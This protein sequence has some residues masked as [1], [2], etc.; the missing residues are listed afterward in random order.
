[1][2]IE[3]VTSSLSPLGSSSPQT[4]QS[5]EV[6]HSPPVQQIGDDQPTFHRQVKSLP[7][8]LREHC[9]IYFE[10]GLCRLS[11]ASADDPCA[12]REYRL[13][14]LEPP[15]SPPDF[16]SSLFSTDTGHPTA[17]TAPGSDSYASSS[18]YLNYAC[19][20]FR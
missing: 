11:K 13:P 6:N 5:A 16:C 2:D 12:D 7:Y 8:E 18:S 1:M 14:S 19:Q 4:F 3:P 17:I 20:D 15:H 10:E 9:M